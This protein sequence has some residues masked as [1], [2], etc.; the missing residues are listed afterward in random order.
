MTTGQP[1]VGK[2]APMP[3]PTPML[4]LPA[5]SH[6]IFCLQH[7]S[8]EAFSLWT[9][10]RPTPK[11]AR[12]Q[13]PTS[14][15]TFCNTSLAMLSRCTSLL[16]LLLEV[17]MFPGLLFSVPMLLFGHS[18]GSCSLSLPMCILDLLT[19]LPPLV[20]LHNTHVIAS[21][22]LHHSLVGHP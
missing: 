5:Y 2:P 15:L 4:V 6:F 13:S 11:S 12:R 19:L 9:H 14:K 10:T 7:S 17:M 18:L 21:V 22:D 8:H 1:L 20:H 3:E 16:L